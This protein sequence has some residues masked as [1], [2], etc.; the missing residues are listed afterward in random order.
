MSKLKIIGLFFSALAIFAI[1][2]PL[3]IIVACS[4]A[5]LW[6]GLVSGVQFEW[7]EMI[8]TRIQGE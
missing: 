7:T 8:K 6:V 5:D 4:I 2:L 3:V 1:I